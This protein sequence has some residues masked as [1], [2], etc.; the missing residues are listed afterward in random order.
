MEVLWEGGGGGGFCMVNGKL[1]KMTGDKKN[2]FLG[3][4]LFDGF[5][6]FG[7]RFGRQYRNLSKSLKLESF[8]QNP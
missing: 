4:Y 5:L 1:N 3:S 2:G 6:K 8:N 7:C